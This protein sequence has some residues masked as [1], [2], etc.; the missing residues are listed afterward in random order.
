MTV[1]D[2][3][4]SNNECHH[5]LV[6]ERG[7]IKLKWTPIYIPLLENS[8]V[9]IIQSRV[10]IATKLERFYCVLKNSE[11]ENRHNLP[12]SQCCEILQYNVIISTQCNVVRNN[13]QMHAMPFTNVT[14]HCTD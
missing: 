2:T 7:E 11:Q 14:K 3:V 9:C 4:M 1:L 13:C 5:S 6:A 8:N 10:K 12:L